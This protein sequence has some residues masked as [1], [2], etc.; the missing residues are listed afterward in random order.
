MGGG[1][2]KP[3]LKCRK[4]KKMLP[5]KILTPKMMIFFRRA[6]GWETVF[7]PWEPRLFLLR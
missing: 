4:G 5:Y 3:T 2:T 6:D 1:I 7:D